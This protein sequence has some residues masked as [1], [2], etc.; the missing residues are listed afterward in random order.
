[1]RTARSRATPWLAV[2]LAAS[3]LVAVKL[4]FDLRT[5]HRD[6][7]AAELAAETSGRTVAERDALIAQLTDPSVELVTMAAAGPTKPAVKAFINR[8]RRT[9]LLTA[10]SMETP[11]AGKAYQ[12]WFIVG[13][14]PVASITFRPDSTGRALVRDVPVPAGAVDATAITEEPEGGSTTPTMPILFVGKHATE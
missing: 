10:A 14:K 4:G 2:A 1:M 9:L 8:N 13:G 6:A 12:L 11:P 7:L 5:A 3:I